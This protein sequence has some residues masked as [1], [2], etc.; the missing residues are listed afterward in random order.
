MAT[1]ETTGWLPNFVWNMEG[2]LSATVAGA[3]LG[4][5]RRPTESL[6]LLLEGSRD[7]GGQLGLAKSGFT[8]LC[9][10]MLL[11]M[12]AA[13]PRLRPRQTLI[14]VYYIYY[15]AWTAAAKTVVEKIVE[16][17]SDLPSTDEHSVYGWWNI[18]TKYYQQGIVFKRY[19]AKKVSCTT[20]T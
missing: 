1:F 11:P 10:V 6:Q 18:N 17:M 15:G 4:L 2:R 13:V 16:S 14:N 12:R 8:Q 7:S 19:V 20:V 5:C 3:P 9:N